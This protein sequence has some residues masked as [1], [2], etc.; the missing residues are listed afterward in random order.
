MTKLKTV[1]LSSAIAISASISMAQTNLPAP[2]DYE[3]LT[4]NPDELVSTQE[5]MATLG[6]IFESLFSQNWEEMSKLYADN[7]VQHNPDMNDGKE[8]VIE[9]FKNLNYEQLVYQPVLQLAEGPYVV[10]MSKLQFA[11]DQPMLGVVDINFIRE[12]KSREHW[13]IIM[14]VE[15]AEKFFAVSKESTPHDQSTVD[16]NKA[17]VADF[18]NVVF[19]QRQHDKAR[20]YIGETY[21]QHGEGNDGV[22]AVIEDAKTRLASVEVDMKRIIGMNDLVLLHSR[23][24]SE[25]KEFSRVDIWRVEDKKL[26][27]HWGL[28]Q[29]VPEEMKHNN[30]MF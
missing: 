3:F 20:E 29:A 1:L 24:T 7:Y 17:L 10:A 30:G 4:V 8:G 22:E 28:M 23:V 14:P 27:E 21:V 11:P 18:V 12:G 9:L 13:D 19:N 25:G 5:N 6:K 26:T 15:D 2:F 16:S